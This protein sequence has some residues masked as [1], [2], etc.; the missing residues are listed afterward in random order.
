MH[1]RSCL[2]LL[3][4]LQAADAGDGYAAFAAG[5]H[6]D[7]QAAFAR[8]IADAGERPDPAMLFNLALAALHAG[9][10]RTAEATARRLGEQ[11]GEPAL[12]KA[13]FLLGNV[14]WA[15]CELATAQASGPEAEPFALDV[16][17]RRARAA[18]AAFARAALGSEDWPAARR[19]AER[20]QLRLH[21]LQRQKAG[22]KTDV[23]KE[24]DQAKPQVVAT[25]QDAQPTDL[26]PPPTRERELTADELQRLF[27]QLAKKD[28][29]K[30]AARTERQRATQ[31]PGER[32]W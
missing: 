8:V 6:A 22:Q 29:Q 10:L 28:Q 24:A 20:A 19:N 18:A 4:L 16:A 23:K 12:T 15:Q 13:A 30:R 17:I 27:D 1:V 14:A 3:P 5:R 32:D 25:P 21:E 7:A 31:A 2:L 26:T 11:G 9:D